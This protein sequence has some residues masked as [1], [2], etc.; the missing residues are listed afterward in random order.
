MR[1]DEGW[2]ASFV[3]PP[4]V[5]VWITFGVL[6]ADLFVVQRLDV[7]L[8]VWSKHHNIH[9]YLLAAILLPVRQVAA[10]FE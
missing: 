5:V 6:T 4:S 3:R 9:L 8:A 7:L 10:S 1:T 2:G